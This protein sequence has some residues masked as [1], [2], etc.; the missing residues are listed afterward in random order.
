[1]P[2][3]FRRALPILILCLAACSPSR[4]APRGTLHDLAA[5]FPVADVQR[6]VGSL[7]F[8]SPEGR[9]HLTSGWYRNERDRGGDT[10]VWSKGEESEI[11]IFL[12]APR[13]L[14]A[15]IRC[16]PI[17]TGGLPQTMQVAVNGRRLGTVA[18]SPGMRDYVVAVP[19]AMLAAGANRLTFHYGTVTAPSL[20]NGRRQL[21]VQW[22]ALRFRPGREPA[23]APPQSDERGAL[24]LPFGTQVTYFVEVP[25]A[26]ELA[27]RRVVEEGA[28]GG[29]LVVA[30]QE[31]GKAA[32]ERE[33]A[34]GSPV[35][36]ELPG[37]GRRLLRISLRAVGP[38]PEAGGG[39][40]VASPVVR[41]E[42]PEEPGRE[43]RRRPWSGKPNII[44]YLVDTLRADRLGCYGSTKSLT[45]SIDAFARGATLFEDT[46][47][48][49]S[50]TRPSVTS[51]LTGFDPLYHG[52]KTT[53]D[54]LTDEAWTLP[55]FLKAAGY[56]TAAFS[57]NPHISAETGLAQGFDDFQLFPEDP[58][59]EAVNR[60]VLGWLDEARGPSPFFLYIHTLDPHAPYQ[61]PF[62]LLARFAPGV[63]PLAGTYEEI[64]RVYAARG[65]E[66][67]RGMEQLAALYDAEVA[68]NDRSF[69]ELLAALKERNLADSTLVVFVAD[70]GEEFDEHGF[71]GHGNNLYNESLRVPLILRWPGQTRGERV[72]SLA[73][74]IDLLPTLL[75]AAGLQP[76][77]V[78]PGDDLF[79]LAGEPFRT[80]RAFSH[81]SYD[82]RDGVSLVNGD[83]KL[84]FPLSFKLGRG[85]ELYRRAADPAERDNLIEQEEIRA[86]WL[87]T[88]I[89]LEL[90][91][92]RTGLQAK[93]AA[94]DEERRKALE[95]LGYL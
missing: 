66:R 31:E 9:S 81:L 5:L 75:H 54:R 47:A 69:G 11:E 6:E 64:R 91:R 29:R 73:Q 10:F 89:R 41:G 33:P 7:D 95:A 68:G 35:R 44:V 58:S 48:Q 36:L 16:A 32:E 61:P 83:W 56:R 27:I 4:E 52:V 23:A 74:H 92:T 24:H 15:E 28:Q 12:A 63:A 62:D 19:K 76:P 14:R 82:G 79:A 80:R 2:A 8:G 67:E 53:E 60:R 93:P 88:Q 37:S 77:D 87:L 40:L 18:M 43:A 34:V 1:M 70:H 85:P 49:A 42:R 50:W 71:L 72:K 86:G 13:D 84:I 21:A 46:V 65:A 17:D 30:L 25:A 51:I 38:T 22:D 55:E 20:D 78:L 3:P 39:L 94:M 45:P 59:S 26:G 90:L 57:T